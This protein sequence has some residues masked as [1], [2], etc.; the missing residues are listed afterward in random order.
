VNPFKHPQRRKI[1]DEMIVAA[2][3]RNSEMYFTTMKGATLRRRGAAHRNAFWEGAEGKPQPKWILKDTLAYACYLAGQ[4][5][6]K[7]VSQSA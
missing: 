5:W 7:S 3:D 2:N 1:F 6:A 4:E